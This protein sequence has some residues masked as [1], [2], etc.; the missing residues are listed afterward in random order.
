MKT[1]EEIGKE[2]EEEIRTALHNIGLKYGKEISWL[3]GENGLNIRVNFEE[4]GIRV[5]IGYYDYDK[6]GSDIDEFFIQY[7][8]TEEMLENNRNRLNAIILADTALLENQTA[9]KNEVIEEYIH[10]AKWETEEANKTIESEEQRIQQAVKEAEVEANKK[11]LN[12]QQRLKINKLELGQL[13]NSINAKAK[14][15]VK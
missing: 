8:T 14:S 5:G 10:M 13:N 4:S 15:D 7:L 6:R 9:I 12:I 2:I 1:N 3:Y 11:I